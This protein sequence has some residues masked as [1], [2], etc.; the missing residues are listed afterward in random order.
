[1]QNNFLKYCN[2]FSLRIH[3][4]KKNLLQKPSSRGV[5]LRRCSRPA[6]LLK[7]EKKKTLAQVLSCEFC[8]SSKN[9]FFIEHIRWLLLLLCS[10]VLVMGKK[11]MD[12]NNCEPQPDTIL[13]VPFGHFIC[14]MWKKCKYIILNIEFLECNSPVILLPWSNVT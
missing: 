12:V 5:L 8:E 13:E 1:M 10:R 3:F 9:T 6:T 11:K 4:G 14:L 2:S 7:I